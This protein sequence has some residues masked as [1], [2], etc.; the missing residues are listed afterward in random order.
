M[1]E[2]KG[3]IFIPRADLDQSLLVRLNSKSSP[4]DLNVYL[5][6]L[7][8]CEILEIGHAINISNDVNFGV[9]VHRTQKATE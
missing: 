1:N 2:I 8:Q 3:G 7:V 9:Y 5:E 4:Y 6:V